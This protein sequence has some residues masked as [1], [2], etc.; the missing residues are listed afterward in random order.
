M[1]YRRDID[2][3]R[4]LAIVPVVLCH[5]GL[6]PFSGGFAGVDIFFVISG[7]L[8]TTVVLESVQQNT[9]S[10]LGFYERR[11]RRLLP[12]LYFSLTLTFLAG[13]VTLT[14]EDFSLM[15]RSAKYVLFFA[16]NIFFLNE[17]DYF[18]QAAEFMPLLHTWSLGV[19][20]QFY[21]FWPY[22]LLGYAGSARSRY[23][24]WA[25]VGLVVAGSFAASLVAMDRASEPAFYLIFFRLWELGVGGITALCLR[26][27]P[28]IQKL[29]PN[30]TY[31]LG[32]VC[33]VGSLLLLS[34][35]SAFPGLNALPVVLGTALMI[36]SGNA[37]AN[38]I[39]RP[40][41]AAPVVFVG[42]ISYSLYLLH[43]PIF[44]LYRNYQADVEF[45]L[46]TALSLITLAF[47][48]AAFSFFLIENPV[49][50]R[51]SKSFVTAFGLSGGGVIW[52]A[53]LAGIAFHGFPSR[54]PN[55]LPHY[56][57]RRVEMLKWDCAQTS[58]SGL[59][60]S[61]C[62]FGADWETAEKRIVLWG[63]SHADHFAPLLQH[64][65]DPATTSALLY[66]QSPPFLDDIN[67][68]SLQKGTTHESERR[69]GLHAALMLW[70]LDA[71]RVDQIVMAAAWSGY[72]TSL[73][74]EN[75]GE[76]D[77][78]NGAHLMEL[79]LL[80]TL[81][82]LPP[83]IP[84]HILSD[85]PRANRELTH[86]LMGRDGIVLRKP[87]M[88][89]GA[90]D[91]SQIDSWHLPTTSVLQRVAASY[92]HV[93]TH[94]LVARF[95]SKTSCDIFIEGRLLYR[96]GHHI[97]RNLSDRERSILVQ[98]LGFKEMLGEA[99]TIRQNATAM[100]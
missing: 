16:S 90:L 12:A 36:V 1:K 81:E 75:P 30:S 49:R 29:A 5:A 54:L 7:F 70:L 26:E 51:A 98:R 72:P 69:G 15:F 17:I 61:H 38:W 95:C 35:Q 67:V 3:L 18:S 84:V 68:R 43:W 37:E 89:C 87:T 92:D 71:P 6:A 46:S 44:A 25:L 80:A 2:G 48:L 28:E 14:P 47:A 76:A 55:D 59:E 32:A 56:A 93:S 99:E 96:D 31:L 20:E 57:S 52:A 74:V 100:N 53:S 24:I 63:D 19:E 41:R 85:M 78:G 40:L 58:I 45:D 83:T 91:R 23:R 42:K 60:G 97:R 22:L 39:A 94:D 62:V 82:R 11:A 21:L 66:R 4:A 50:R 27:R 10:L 65:I 88:D 13:A 64:A 79:G 86:C 34:E 77:R 9:F 33:V 73:F 8:I